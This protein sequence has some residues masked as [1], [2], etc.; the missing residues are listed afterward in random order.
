MKHLLYKELRLAKHPTMFLFLL[1]SAMLLIPSYPYYV[2]FIYTCLSVFLVFLQ[3]RENNDLSFTA[4]LPVRKRDIVRARCLLVVLM[5]LAQVLVSLP[6][7]IVGARINPLGG[8]AAGI[9]AN[10]AFFGLVLVM[11]AL[12]N[13]LFLPAFYRTGYR[14]GRAFLFAGAAVLVYIVAAEL[15]VQCVPALKASL[16]TFDPATRGTRLFVLLLGAGLYA[17]GSLLACRLSERRFARVDL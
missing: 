7:A 1:F 4:L 8:N 14:V 10:A 2:A 13:L 17:A 12:F 3:G 5:Q 15:L 9:E 16:D 6:C 11:Y